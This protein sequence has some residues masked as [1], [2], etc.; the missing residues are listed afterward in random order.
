M[1]L[2]VFSCLLFCAFTTLLS[3]QGAQGQLAT[4]FY[5]VTDIK[6]TVLPNAVRIVIRTD[7]TLRFGGDL[8]EWINFENFSPKPTTSFRL[9]LAGARAKLPAFV[10]IGTYPVE[11]AV[12]TPGRVDI[13]SPYF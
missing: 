7:G 12:I 5:N 10:N 9:R 1:N 3:T 11:A 13:T 6:A 8:S 2:R 4:S